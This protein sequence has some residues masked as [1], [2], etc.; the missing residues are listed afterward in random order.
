MNPIN[1]Q[2]FYTIKTGPALFSLYTQ[3]LI[4]VAC[5]KQRFFTNQNETNTPKQFS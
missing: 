2:Q 1:A 5:N 4:F 3:S